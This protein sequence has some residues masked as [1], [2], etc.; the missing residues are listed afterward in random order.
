MTESSRFFSLEQ[1]CYPYICLPPLG[2]DG[3]DVITPAHIPKI[4]LINI[5]DS[6]QKFSPGPG[7]ESGSSALK[8]DELPTAPRTTGP[9]QKFSLS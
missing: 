8:A 4:A 7:F 9:S 3:I 2:T 1:Q 6:R 5:F